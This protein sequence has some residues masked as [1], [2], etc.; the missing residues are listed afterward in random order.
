MAVIK[1]ISSEEFIKSFTTD[2]YVNKI[3]ELEEEKS[4]L[5]KSPSSANKKR[6]EEIDKI[7]K[8]LYEESN[9]VGNVLAEVHIKVL[10]VEKIAIQKVL[11]AELIHFINKGLHPYDEPNTRWISTNTYVEYKNNF[12]KRVLTIDNGFFIDIQKINA[13]VSKLLE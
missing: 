11:I 1:E 5:E 10:T 9:Y 12:E 4:K 7:I 8:K 2:Y 6:I 3:K 13:E